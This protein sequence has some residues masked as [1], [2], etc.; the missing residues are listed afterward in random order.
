MV[1]SYASQNFSQV[2]LSGAC[3]ADNF[4]HKGM[5]VDYDK[6]A[7]TAQHVPDSFAMLLMNFKKNPKTKI[8]NIQPN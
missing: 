8:L 5:Q 1:P 6:K 2:S 3:H 7:P 4:P